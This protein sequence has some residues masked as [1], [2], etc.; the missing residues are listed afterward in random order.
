MQDAKLSGI[1]SNS[2]TIWPD[3]PSAEEQTLVEEEE[4]AT[5]EEEVGTIKVG[6]LHSL[7]GS[8]A[9]SEAPVRDATLL[10]IN[11]INAAGGVLRQPLVPVVEDGASDWQF[12]AEKALKLLA[13]DKVAVVFGCWTS[14]SRQA[15]RPIFESLNG[16][17]FYPVQY[18]GQEQS[19]NIIYTGAEPS[20]QIIPAVE[21]L[22]RQG[23]QKIFLLG[24]DYIFP[25]TANT[26]IKAQL[27]NAGGAV[28]GEEYLRLG[29]SDFSAIISQI[30]T[31]Q[32]DAIFNTLNGESNVA[33]FQQL[34]G[35]GITPEQ[36]PVMSVS[37][38]E[39][40]VRQIGTEN[41]AGHLT[42]WTYYQTIDTPQNEGFVT[43]YKIAYGSEGVTSEP[44][45][46][47]YFGVY[48]WKAMVE[49]ANSTEVD[50]I[51]KAL[52]KTDTDEQEPEGIEI[53]APGGLIRV[54]VGNQHTYKIARIGVIREDG[55]IDEIF[56]SNEP[57]KPDPLLLG[58]EW[59][60]GLFS[61]DGE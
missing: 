12:F 40:E 26:I 30:Q 27:A 51:R 6:I 29:E 36:M 1:R 15:V 46:A 25:R 58:Y 47:G 59:A 16:L 4:K 23:N 54:D 21:Y 37:I 11:E 55:L 60:V 42:A 5:Q 13:E 44:I 53:M 19:A 22:L 7:S 31:A 20:Q 41:I 52:T 38:A 9:I 35:A 24:S 48:L 50:T 61:K 28:V 3:Q 10:A 57:I 33:F 45:H 32:P 18:E 56:S 43:A 8:L 49:K 2:E 39:E 34:K 17:L 14:T